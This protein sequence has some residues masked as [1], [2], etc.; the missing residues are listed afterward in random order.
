[1]QKVWY[2]FVKY[3]VRLAIKLFYRRIEILGTED[4]PTDGPVLLAPNHQNAFMDALIPAVFAPRPIHFL[5][6]ADVFKSKFAKW[7]FHSL[8]MMPVYRQRD[9]MANLAKNEEVF[10]MCFDI[11]RNNGTLL[12]FPEA[13][14]LGERRLRPL[15]KGFTRI[16]FG[17]MEDNEHLNINIVP[18][19]LNYSNYHQSQSRLLI[20]Y[21]HPIAVRDFVETHRESPARAMTQLRSVLQKDLENQIIHIEPKHSQRAFEIEMERILP[22][23]LQR[24]SG[25]SQAQT[26]HEFYKKREDFY[27]KL[28]AESSYYNKLIIYDQI[29][30]KKRLRA[31][32]FFIK[33]KDA[34]Y[35]FIQNI[36]LLI[37][38]PLFALSWLIHAPTY[39]TI[40]AV[41]NKFVDD[42]QFYSSIK[43]VGTLFLF[44]LFGLIFAVAAA[45]I[46]KRPLLAL[47][48]V[49]VFFP[50]SIFVIR[51][52]RLPYRY[53]LTMWGMLWMKLRNKDLYKYLRSIEHNILNTLK[54]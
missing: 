43:L 10:E 34:G 46:T 26:Q 14:H 53:T 24:T 5:V 48:I 30:K 37:F 27:C 50:L 41:L 4:Y 42:R 39:F 25:F 19:G 7:F 16:V 8:N 12:I 11:L 20:S 36:L 22:F 49:G 44:P 52:L 29:M 45:I 54:S 6:R 35:W 1:M 51:E 21:G 15:S 28:D 18:L 2:A 40:R 32:F 9:G 47:S 33:Q 23:Y 13:G 3:C 17:A 38:L 31:P